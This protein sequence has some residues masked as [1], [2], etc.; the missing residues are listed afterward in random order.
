MVCMC[1]PG[2]VGDANVA[3]NLRK[4]VMDKK[5]LNFLYNLGCSALFMTVFA[6]LQEL[7]YSILFCRTRRFSLF[8]TSIYVV[9]ACHVILVFFVYLVPLRKEIALFLCNFLFLGGPP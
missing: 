8:Y 4:T 6:S 9:M 3:C 2:Y 5:I 7:L 1:R